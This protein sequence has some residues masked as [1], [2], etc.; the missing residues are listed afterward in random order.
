MQL[1]RFNASPKHSRTR[2]VALLTYTRRASSFQ[3]NTQRRRKGFRKRF[4][5]YMC[6]FEIR[7]SAWK[8]RRRRRERRPWNPSSSLRRP[9]R[10]PSSWT[11]C[12][13]WL[14][15]VPMRSEQSSR[16]RRMTLAI[17]SL[18]SKTKRAKLALSVRQKHESA[19]DWASPCAK[20]R[21]EPMS[22]RKPGSLSMWRSAKNSRTTSIGL[23][24]HLMPRLMKSK[25]LQRR[26]NRRVVNWR[27][28]ASRA[29]LQV[30]SGA[31]LKQS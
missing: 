21:R 3:Q 18:S 7:R 12:S 16:K 23:M 10:G 15:P 30:Q 14:G 9:R 22:L 26:W 20:S 1:R 27:R 4:Q 2:K 13:R 29:R 6:R 19:S 17:A 31:T 8:T 25:C 28:R 5:P 24:H 11:Q